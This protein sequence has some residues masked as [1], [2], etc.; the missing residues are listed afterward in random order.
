MRNIK[1][2]KPKKG[3][4]VSA[5]EPQNYS[6]SPIIFSLEKIQNCK[7]CFSHLDRINRAYFADAIYKRKS[8]T[9]EDAY[10]AGKH[11]LGTE[12]IAVGA[13]KSP[14]PIFVTP[15]ET[16]Y[17][18]FRYHD[19]KAMVGLRERDVFYVLWFDCDFTLYDH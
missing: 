14:K 2:K 1:S 3:V 10:R 18:A 11:G 9:W 4:L 5:R 19:R 17:I 7:Y 8:L 6:K 15:D 13:V 12:K 16:N